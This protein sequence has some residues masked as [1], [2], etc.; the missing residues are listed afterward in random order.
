MSKIK[1]RN[2]LITLDEDIIK[3]IDEKA[4]ALAMDR[5]HFLNWYFRFGLQAETKPIGDVL[6][7]FVKEATERRKE[8][9]KTLGIDEK[10][11]KN[12]V[13]D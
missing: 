8:V 4:K 2:I 6:A 12:R 10:E 7:N 9:K 13:T 5:S 3:S 1:T 11:V